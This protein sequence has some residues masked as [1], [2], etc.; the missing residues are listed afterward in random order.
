MEAFRANGV[1]HPRTAVVTDSPHA[2]MSLL[3]TGRFVTILPA[4]VLKFPAIRTEIKA[5]PVHLPRARVPNGIITLKTR[6][7][8]P[9]AQLFI[10]CAREVAKTPEKRMR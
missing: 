4:S 1:D 2:R 3:A 8:S 6:T 10:D 5:L 7:L 9:V